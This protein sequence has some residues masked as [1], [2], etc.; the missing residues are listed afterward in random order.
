MRWHVELIA[1]DGSVPVR[2]NGV[3]PCHQQVPH[4]DV[5]GQHPRHE[6]P[7]LAKSGGRDGRR[8]Q[9]GADTVVLHAIIDGHCQ[10]LDPGAKRLEDKVS[11]N[12]PTFDSH[13]A[14]TSPVVRCREP[15]GLLITDPVGRAVEAQRPT[16]GRKVG[17]EA[18]ELFGVVGADP[19]HADVVVDHIRIVVQLLPTEQCRASLPQGPSGTAPALLIQVKPS[20]SQPQVVAEVGVG[21]GDQRPSALCHRPPE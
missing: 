9:Q 15:L 12:P 6:S 20:C 16:F 14:V 7:N 1:R 13:E 17:V 10:L 21:D 5:V 11:N 4:S 2:A 8:E 19:P 18:L 3:M